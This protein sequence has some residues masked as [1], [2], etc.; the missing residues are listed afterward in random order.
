MSTET[1]EN[2][3]SPAEDEQ[4]T[5]LESIAKTTKASVKASAKKPKDPKKVAAGRKLAE[6]NRIEMQVLNRELK[7]E[8]EAEAKTKAEAGVGDSNSWIPNTSFTTVLSVVGISLT[9]FDL[10][11]RYRKGEGAR[12]GVSKAQVSRVDEK[13]S[14]AKAEVK[15]EAKEE[16]VI[17]PVEKSQ[18]C[19][20]L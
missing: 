11:M 8:S 7:R 4:I 18:D 1:Q 19:S 6:H 15:A 2:I 5:K 14:E 17:E 13:S 3:I 10:Y 20:L 9:I 12:E 16:S